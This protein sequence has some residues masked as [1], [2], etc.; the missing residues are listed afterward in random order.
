V[1]RA[2]RAT[3]LLALVAGLAAGVALAM[4]AAGRRTSTSYERFAGYADIPELLLNF[5]P[6]GVTPA[7]E[8]ELAQC[9]SYD[10]S[11]ERS[12][13]DRLPEVESTAR[14]EFRGATIAPA[15]EPA[16]RTL[17]STLAMFDQGIAGVAGRYRVLEGSDAEAADEIV[18]SEHLADQGFAVG[19]EVVLTFWGPDQLGTFFEGATFDGP[20]AKVRV[21]GIA[22][23]LIDV[24]ASDEGFGA[25]D[26]S[27][28]YTGPGLAEATSDAGGFAGVLVDATD[29]DG[30]AATAAI[31]DAFGD[32]PL[33]ITPALGEDETSPS[34]DAI[35]YGGQAVSTLGVVVGFVVALFLAQ[36]AA[37][38]SRREWDDGPVLRAIGVT[39]GTAISCALVRSLAISVP[40]IALALVTAVALSP[41]GPVGLGR[42]AEIDPGVHVDPLVLALGALALL[43]VVSLAVAAP[44]L[45][46]RVLRPT[47]PAAPRRA[48]ARAIS[49]PPVLS[50]SRHL[51]RR[52]RAGAVVEQ[53]TA[54]IGVAAAIAVAIAAVSLAASFDDLV[55]TP[56]RFGA[57]WDLSVASSAV[58]D[59]GSLEVASDEVRDQIA[60]AAAISGTDMRVDGQAAW[61]QSFTPIEGIDGVVPVPISEGRAP[62]NDKEI[63]LGEITLRQIDKSIGDTVTVAS[64][65]TGEYD[66]EVVGITMINDTFEASPGRG[67]VVTPD[68]IAA[69]APEVTGDPLVINLAPGVDRDE[70]ADV[71]RAT[72][73]GVVQPPLQQAALRNVGRIRYLPFVT[74]GVVALLAIASLVHALVLSVG[75]NRRAL[76]VLKSLGFRRIQVAETVAFQANAFGLVALVL[77][78]PMGVFAGRQ[79]WGL[80]AE[81]LGVPEVPVV[82]FIPVVAVVVL[83]LIVVNLI[84]AYPAWRAARLPTAVALRSE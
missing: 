37:R 39:R 5:C 43:V 78:V 38:Q 15:D 46:G 20:E 17:A 14:G 57:T 18:I 47:P 1:R 70:F 24:T 40:A 6:P 66:L 9:F 31:Q 68:F 77:A 58:Q 34:R 12:V 61:I 82:P 19:D 83:A 16:H 44:V 3:V 49:V 11:A 60:E 7:S 48:A 22:R 35:H 54:L 23:A 2:L 41:L 4:V 81:G 79:L 63:A 59:N 25:N 72:Q 30:P 80:I 36:L 13:L 62:S 45:R 33:N 71:L 64:T 65:S 26:E 52:G 56:A 8:D 69:A 67:G 27:L 73:V 84:A 50:A 29:D 51:A 53:S 75:R 21:T 10:P 55:D 42:K 32:R 28:I 76:G 74:A